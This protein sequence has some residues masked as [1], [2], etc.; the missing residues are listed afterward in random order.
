[1]GGMTY[2][3]AVVEAYWLMYGVAIWLNCRRV[4]AAECGV[5]VWCGVVWSVRCQA[6]V[7]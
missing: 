3:V 6:K 1:M 7:R 4:D 5:V 2:A